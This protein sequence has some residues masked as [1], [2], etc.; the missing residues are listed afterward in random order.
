MKASD[1]ANY[2]NISGRTL[3]RA[4]LAGQIPYLRIG[5]SYRFDLQ[6]VRDALAKKKG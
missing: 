4:V 2:M 6:A 3:R 1:L 5:G